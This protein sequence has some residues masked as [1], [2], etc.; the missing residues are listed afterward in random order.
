M[1]DCRRWSQRLESVPLAVGIDALAAGMGLGGGGEVERPSTG[2][3]AWRALRATT[4]P[5]IGLLFIMSTSNIALDAPV[6]HTL[7]VRVGVG[8]SKFLMSYLCHTSHNSER[9]CAGKASRALG[10]TRA[11]MNI[12]D[13]HLHTFFRVFKIDCVHQT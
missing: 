11:R 12:C 1:G 3:P 9:T 2:P 4:A 7:D 13:M 8:P 6:E 10:P 5:T